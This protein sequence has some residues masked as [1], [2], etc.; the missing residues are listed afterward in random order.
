MVQWAEEQCL[1]LEIKAF[2]EKLADLK[3][4]EGGLEHRVFVYKEMGRVIKL[5]KPPN[6]GL[7]EDLP[8]YV[9][10]LVR[11]NLVFGDDVKVVG[12]LQ[13]NDG[14]ALVTSQEFVPGKSPSDSQVEQWFSGQGCERLAKHIWKYPDGTRVADTHSRNFILT[15]ENQIVPIDLHVEVLGAAWEGQLSSLLAAVRGENAPPVAD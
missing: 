14:A 10:N 2:E 15:K 13:T 12:V 11:S 7:Y 3:D 1:V 4:L 5:T 8:I 6:F 9:R